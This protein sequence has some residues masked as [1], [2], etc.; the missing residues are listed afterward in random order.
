MV[1][2]SLHPSV[3]W[4]L[5]GRGDVV[6]GIYYFSSGRPAP[7]ALVGQLRSSRFESKSSAEKLALF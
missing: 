1:Y 4:Q 6:M 5:S 2:G 3:G 7:L